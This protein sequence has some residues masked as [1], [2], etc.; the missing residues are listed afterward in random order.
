MDLDI[1]YKRSKG[2]MV[3]ELILHEVNFDKMRHKLINF[4]SL[5]Q[6]TF[7]ETTYLRE[8]GAGKAPWIT[9]FQKIKSFKFVMPSSFLYPELEYSCCYYRPS[10]NTSS[11][12][13]QTGTRK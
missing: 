9:P 10:S 7:T 11:V 8:E 1:I 6:A 13:I 5:L 2:L 3:A 12:L 4:F